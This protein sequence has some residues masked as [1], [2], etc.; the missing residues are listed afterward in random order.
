[1][2]FMPRS[3]RWLVQQGRSDEALEALK[4]VR[5]EPEAESELTEIQLSHEEA[6]VGLA[7]D[8]AMCKS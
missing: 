4:L 5:D 7:I 1:M 6:K 8:R 2:P 3:P